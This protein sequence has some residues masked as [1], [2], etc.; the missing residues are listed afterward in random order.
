MK[1]GSWKKIIS[2]LLAVVMVLGLAACGKGGDESGNGP[3]GNASI[4]SGGKNNPNVGL[5]KQFVFHGNEISLPS[6]ELGDDYYIQGMSYAAGKL[7]IVTESYIY[8]ETNG[9]DGED[10]TE[11]EGDDAEDGTETEGDTQDVM[12]AVGVAAHEIPV[13]AVEEYVPPVLV[14]KLLSMD[15]DGGNLQVYDL[16][17]EESDENTNFWYNR[18]GVGLNGLLYGVQTVNFNDYSDPDNPIYEENIYLVCWGMDGKEKWKVPLDE[19]IPEDEYSYVSSLSVGEDGVATVIMQGQSYRV[20]MIGEDGVLQQSKELDTASLDIENLSTSFMNSD[21]TMTFVTYN[22]EYTKMFYSVFDPKTGT[23]SEKVPLPDNVMYYSMYGGADGSM[24]LANN[25]GIFTYNESAGEIEQ[26]MSFVNSDLSVSWLNNLCFIDKEHFAGTYYD[27][28][29]NTVVAVFNKVNPE[30]IPDKV[31]LILGCEYLNS[32]IR[33][34][35]VDFNKTNERYRITVKD[36]SQY[37]TMDDYMAGYTQLNNDIISGNMPEILVVDGNIPVENYIA[38]GLIADV[39]ALLEKDGELSQKEFLQNVFDAYSIDGTLY[40]VVP[41][42]TINTW[43]AKTSLLGGRTE[44]N[45]E[46]FNEVMASLPEGTVAY[47]DMTRGSF[48]NSILQFCGTQF[49]DQSTGECHFES[50]EFMNLMEFAKTLPEEINYDDDYD[51]SMYETQYRENRTLLMPMTLYNFRSWHRIQYAQFGEDITCIGFP[52]EEGSGSVVS[53]NMLFALSSRSVALD[54]AWEFVRY[55]LGDEYQEQMKSNYGFPVDK[56]CLLEVAQE[57]TE[58]PYWEDEDGN[59]EYYDDTYYFNDEDVII[60]PST[61]EEVDEML[62]FIES[63][64][65]LAY[66]NQDILDII[67]E[68]TAPFFSGQKSAEEVAHIIQSRVQIFVNESR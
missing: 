66:Y 27:E 25:N 40:Y 47:G 17:M 32:N 1:K 42:F 58:R 4:P 65:R 11:T 39:G 57:A 16:E 14:N 45:T 12:A 44:W 13:D 23:I 68:E 36:Y 7:Y 52:T 62:N 67:Q 30:D 46:Q 50:E 61:Q 18:I 56:K 24:M 28:D 54:G 33:R 5:A 26:V 60:P 9:D 19:D 10:G 41:S 63:V 55:Y 51:W 20:L 34:Q 2:L 8:P 49:V 64:D 6:E 21:G 43:A 22:N 37:E 48:F 53:G 29:Y 35:I 38:K 3:D 31:V 15:L 59:R